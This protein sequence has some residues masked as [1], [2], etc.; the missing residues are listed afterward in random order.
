MNSNTD[1]IK[2]YTNWLYSQYK[3]SEISDIK[4]ITTPFTNS[5]GDN[6]RL[7]IKENKEKITIS[8]DGNT[9]NDLAMLG[10]DLT[11]KTRSHYIDS[12]LQQY[13]VDMFEEVIKVTGPKDRFPIIKQ[14]ILQAILKIDD[15][16]STRHENLKIFFLMILLTTLIVMIMVALL[17]TH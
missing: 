9:I 15:L 5:I 6:F 1:W 17:V 7:Y 3:R 14:N 11:T 4:E 16:Y 10:V 2:E 8:D 13:G 12:V